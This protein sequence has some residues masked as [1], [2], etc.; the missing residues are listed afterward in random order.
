MNVGVVLLTE[1]I[2]PPVIVVSGAGRVDRRTSARRASGPARPTALSARTWNVCVPCASAAVVCGDVQRGERRGVDPALEAGR[3]ATPVKVNV[4]VLSLVGFGGPPVIVV[5]S[6][7]TVNERVVT[8]GF[9][10]SPSIA[11]TENV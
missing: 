3:A 5:S 7:A 8:G 1:S 4:G 11:R 10:N 9:V 6:A 2:G